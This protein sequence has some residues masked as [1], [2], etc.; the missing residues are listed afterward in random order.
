MLVIGILRG[1]LNAVSM[2]AVGEYL[3]QI[4]LENDKALSVFFFV[5]CK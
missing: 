2:I 3:R 5:M 1:I 4:L